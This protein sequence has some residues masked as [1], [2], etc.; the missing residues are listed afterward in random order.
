MNPSLS[1]PNTQA[2]LEYLQKWSAALPAVRL[3]D[4]SRN[5]DEIALFT[6]DLTVGFC[7]QGALSSP[8]V[9]AIV[10][11]IADLMKL[12]HAHGVEHYLLPQDTHEENAVEFSAFPPHCVRGSEESETAPE[13]KAL[14]FYNKMLV[15]PKNSID[16]RYNPALQDWLTN[17]PEVDTFLITGDC[18]DLCVYQLAMFLRIEANANQR[19]RRVIVPMNCVDTYDRTVE[20]A[21]KEG[22]FPHDATLLH[23]LFLYHMALNDIE[24]VRKI[25]S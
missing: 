25:E 14:P 22:G 20:T 12:A 23:V 9:N 3:T 8:R 2:F 18:T 19:K 15:F 6:V 4:I 16:S 13:I 17:H 24:I 1:N 7:S 11:P 10:E 5:P 21:R